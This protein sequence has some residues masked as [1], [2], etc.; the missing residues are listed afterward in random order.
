[1]NNHSNS[2]VA[3][4][5][6]KGSRKCDE[7]GDVSHDDSVENTSPGLSVTDL[8]C[9]DCGKA[10]DTLGN[11]NRHVKL[12]KRCGSAEFLS[13]D[14]KS[15]SLPNETSENIS[16][17]AF[18]CSFCKSVLSTEKSYNVHRKRFRC[19]RRCKF[20]E[21]TAS[22]SIFVQNHLRREHNSFL[23]IDEIE[24]HNKQ[25]FSN[26]IDELDAKK[27]EASPKKHSQEL[28]CP[29]YRCTFST[30][31]KSG[32]VVHIKHHKAEI[33]NSGKE[34]LNCET[35]DTIGIPKEKLINHKC[36]N[37]AS[38]SK[39]QSQA[40]N[41]ENGDAINVSRADNKLL[42]EMKDLQKKKSSPKKKVAVSLKNKKKSSPASRSI[43]MPPLL[44]MARKQSS[45]KKKS[46]L[47]LKKKVM[48]KSAD[49]SCF[50]CKFCDF[51][52]ASY[53]HLAEH[54]NI[55]K[56][57]RARTNSAAKSDT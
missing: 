46:K 15:I 1:L 18:E 17:T 9:P 13:D 41:D 14:K 20:C 23:T 55:H 45:P 35:C 16:Q 25:L 48:N 34:L 24:E 31:H 21:F 27:L 56:L 5:K 2:T 57:K 33:A 8:F 7:N 42:D 11:L 28:C 19:K 6:K 30:V 50:K 32:Q 53:K 47:T 22:Q 37:Q 40:P 51:V 54:M 29:V 52:G 39:I 10:F 36:L 26:H 38:D 12:S 3:E 43:A 44:K 4:T 49:D